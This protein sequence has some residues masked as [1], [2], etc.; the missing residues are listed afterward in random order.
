M[1]SMST[2][3]SDFSA[4]AI[5]MHSKDTVTP[6]MDMKAIMTH[7]PKLFWACAE[8]DFKAASQM[9]NAATSRLGVSP[10]K[11]LKDKS[12][13]G[14]V[15]F[16][17]GSGSLELVRFLC[18]PPHCA[19]TVGSS[20]NGQTPVM[21]AAKHGRLEVVQFLA[22]NHGALSA[23]GAPPSWAAWDAMLPK[24][25]APP[26]LVPNLAAPG[27]P[28]CAESAAAPP[29][30]EKLLAVREYIK[31]HSGDAPAGPAWDRQTTRVRFKQVTPNSDTSTRS[32]SLESS[33][34]DSSRD[35]LRTRRGL[36]AL[37]VNLENRV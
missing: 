2:M 13:Y 24:V 32:P 37:S 28:E 21:V 20:D 19:D 15:H 25:E 7:S 17:C 27:P 31:K 4:P 11:M 9:L 12:G 30:I 23:V 6:A 34:G 33:P 14:L 8:G 22:Q 35:S 10:V 3:N 16:A 26:Q 36:R 18:G 29:T 5:R 1:N